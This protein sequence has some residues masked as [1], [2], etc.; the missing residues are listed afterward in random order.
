MCWGVDDRLVQRRSTTRHWSWSGWP[1]RVRSSRYTSVVPVRLKAS[2]ARWG[3]ETGAPLIARYLGED[4][5]RLEAPRGTGAVSL[6]LALPLRDRESYR[7]KA[8]L[9]MSP[10]GRMRW[11]DAMPIRSHGPPS[12]G[13]GSPVDYLAGN[14]PASRGSLRS[15]S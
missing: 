6:D 7:L 8:G 12:P 1:R 10:R 14:R 2:R 3:S 9:E 5:A 13:G 11:M 15:E 4:F